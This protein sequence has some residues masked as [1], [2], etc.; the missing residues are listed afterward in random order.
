[1][2]LALMLGFVVASAV[3]AW[4]LH[5]VA[6]AGL[7]VW[8]VWPELR[9]LWHEIDWNQSAEATAA[10]TRSRSPAL[11]TLARSRCRSYS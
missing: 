6:L 4:G 2:S 11:A 7:R 3:I 1:M 10:F 5:R 9:S 8:V